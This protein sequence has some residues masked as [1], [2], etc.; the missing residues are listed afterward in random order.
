MRNTLSGT[1]RAAL[2]L[3]GAAT[4]LSCRGAAPAPP[5]AGATS[6]GPLRT[7]ERSALPW[8]PLN[9]ARG[10]RSPR[11]A[12]LWGD[13]RAP[14][15]TGFLVQFVDGFSSPP[16]IHNITYRGVVIEGL[17]HN[18]DPEA[19][20]TWMGPGS[21]WVQP[22]GDVHITSA[23]G[24]RGLAYIEIES[25]PYL[26]RPPGQAF[27]SPDAAI[28]ILADA[29]PWSG[30]APVETVSP[31]GAVTPEIPAQRTMV[32]IAPGESCPLSSEGL[33]RGVVIRGTVELRNGED[34]SSPLTAGSFFE[35]ES[36]R[37]TL[38][39]AS[40]EPCQLYLRS[41]AQN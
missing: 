24:G 29:I 21:Y 37:G 1:T 2:I 19:E 6:R 23:R 38:T 39:C 4:G 9:P 26:V 11:A 28:N 12:N 10:D 20:E 30:D 27:E 15:A 41:S 31:W 36:A 33:L 3:A 7:L 8:Q 40:P 34:R 5:T 17:I 18:D 14:A 25:G 35:W 16:H 13:L 22:A 32:R